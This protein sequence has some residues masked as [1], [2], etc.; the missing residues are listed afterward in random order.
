MAQLV[1]AALRIRSEPKSLQDAF[2]IAKEV[3]HGKG[4]Q[5]LTL[6]TAYALLGLPQRAFPQVQERWK[7]GYKPLE[8][9]APYTAH[10]LLVDVFFHI[11]VDKGL[12]SPKRASNR[13]DLAYLYYLPFTMLFV[14]NDKLHRRVAPLFL[15]EGQDFVGGQELKDDLKALDAHYSARPAAE[16]DEGLFRIASRPP[17]DDGF[18]TTRLWKSLRLPVEPPKPIPNDGPLNERLLEEV[19][20]LHEGAGRSGRGSFTPSELRDPDHVSITRMIPRKRGKWRL[21]PAHLKPTEP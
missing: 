13:V 6:K 18:L 15:K 20:K 9:Y 2:S 16:L 10:C 1:K 8:E 7:R 5:F 19:R 11:A 3:V 4:Q 14:S 17:N 21:L 12:I